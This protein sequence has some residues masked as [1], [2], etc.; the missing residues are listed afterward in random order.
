MNEATRHRIYK[1]SVAVIP[2]LVVYGLIAENAAPVWL[3]LL[4][5]VF[6]SALAAVNT[7]SDA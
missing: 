2:I 5:A 6:N 1:I 7:S 3:G 4:N